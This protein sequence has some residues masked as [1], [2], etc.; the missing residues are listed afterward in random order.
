VLPLLNPFSIKAL[1]ESRRG[2]ILDL[3]QAHEQG[4]GSRVEEGRSYADR[5]VP[6]KDLAFPRLAARKSDQAAP[7]KIQT[8]NLGS[9]EAAIRSA[10][11]ASLSSRR[12][13]E[14]GF[15]G[16]SW[17]KLSMASVVD[18]IELGREPLAL[19]LHRSGPDEDLLFFETG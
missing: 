7:A 13:E 18:D 12:E 17:I 19:R 3:P 15:P 14:R 9:T 16:S 11:T 5:V 10:W 2:P 4:R 8:I 6:W 1:H